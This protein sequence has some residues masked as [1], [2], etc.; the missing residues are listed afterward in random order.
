[1]E[2]M[3]AVVDGDAPPYAPCLGRAKCGSR[4]RE[5]V[6]YKRVSFKR[7][8]DLDLG[9]VVSPHHLDF[10][11]KF[12]AVDVGGHLER[13]EVRGAYRLKPNRLPDARGRRVPNAF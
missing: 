7:D 13:M 6:L 8:R 5:G 2:R 1:L 9:V 11:V 10:K 4:H 3:P 12:V